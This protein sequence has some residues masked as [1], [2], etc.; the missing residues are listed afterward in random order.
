[1]SNDRGRALLGSDYD[2]YVPKGGRATFDGKSLQS[3]LAT[4][5]D[6]FENPI[7][8]KSGNPMAGATA[9]QDAFRLAD[10]ASGGGPRAA[11]FAPLR[12]IGMDMGDMQ[13]YADK[14]GIKNVNSMSDRR[15][16]ADAFLARFDA[17]DEA[18]AEKMQP[19]A[20]PEPQYEF[21]RSTPYYTK[22]NGTWTRNDIVSS[23][24]GKMA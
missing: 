10:I 1:M 12:Q 9:R 18:K 16:I 20:P 21:G 3:F 8:G 15:A 7:R 2:E 13:F 19:S 17:G 14:A 6:Y 11:F 5:Y 4:D 24:Q 22:V 23:L